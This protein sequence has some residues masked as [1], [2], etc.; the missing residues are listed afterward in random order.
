M[1]SANWDCWTSATVVHSNC[2]RVHT[3]I[4]I[5]RTNMGTVCIQHDTIAH[6]IESKQKKVKGEGEAEGLDIYV[7]GWGGGGR[8]GEEKKNN[9]ESL[10]AST[11]E[12]RSQGKE[13]SEKGTKG[14]WRR[15]KATGK[16]TQKNNNQGIFS[17]LPPR[18]AANRRHFYLW[19]RETG[20]SSSTL[21]WFSS[22]INN[23]GLC[24]Q[25]E[26]KRAS[27]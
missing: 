11:S 26:N 23:T 24:S 1:K 4:R 14:R 6:R 5:L 7:G 2:P 12:G 17:E 18:D 21:K 16:E 15:K 13:S 20:L 9:K 3:H 22:E 19:M 25:M 10:H 27:L 8:G